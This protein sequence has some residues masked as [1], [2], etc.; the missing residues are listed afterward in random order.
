[1]WLWPSLVGTTSDSIQS[2]GNWWNHLKYGFNLGTTDIWDWIIL[3][4]GR[5]HPSCRKFSSIADLG[6]TGPREM[7]GRGGVISCENCRGPVSSTWKLPANVCNGNIKT[8]SPTV[9]SYVIRFFSP[10]LTPSSLTTSSIY[11][12]PLPSKR[13]TIHLF[14]EIGGSPN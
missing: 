4:G 1:M 5:E 6:I 3:C 7:K 9:T 14:G 13:N 10:L 8:S 2:L 11:W 12:W